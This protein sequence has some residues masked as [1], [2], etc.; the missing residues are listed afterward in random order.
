M[1][2]STSVEENLDQATSA[3]A[4]AADI[5]AEQ[6]AD[7]LTRH[8]DFFSGNEYLLEKLYVPH[9]RGNTVSL[10]ERQ[11]SLL[12]EK[13]RELHDYLGDMLG[14]A[15]END[16]QFTKTKNMILALMDAATLDDV[17][18]AIDESLCQDFNSDTT[19]LVL[20][21]DQSEAQ[22]NL[23]LMPRTEA[24]AIDTLVDQSQTRCGNLTELQNQ[25]LFRDQAFRVKSA[26][27]V[28]LVKGETLGI[29]AIGSYD[30]SYFQSNQGTLFLDYIGQA[31]S[32]VVSPLLQDRQA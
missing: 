18:V 14:V 4:N 30:A 9:Q 1:S 10:V 2:D 27:A 15:R 29:L 28:P 22:N 20:F 6:V 16:I 21:S 7:Y 25:F 17:A 26:A 24:A 31:L 12:R 32:R 19:A 3:T 5:S 11:T 8:P 13:N 23:R